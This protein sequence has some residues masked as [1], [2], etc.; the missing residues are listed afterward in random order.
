MSSVARRELP[1]VSCVVYLTDRNIEKTNDEFTAMWMVKAL[2]GDEI[3][4]AFT[5]PM[6]GGNTRTFTKA[7]VSEF[8]KMIPARMAKAILAN[9][10][11][12]ATLVPIPNSTVTSPDASD[13]KTL[14]LARDIAANSEGRLKAVPA[15]VFSEP[16]VSSR[17][18]GSRSA[19][20]LETVYRVVADV[21]GPIVLVDD[22]K[23]KSVHLLAAC[24]K[25]ESPKREVVLACTFGNTV[26]EHLDRPLSNRVEM[27]SIERAN[28]FSF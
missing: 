8:V 27:L 20:H 24:W 3:T 22:V 12:S 23:A 10:D 2:K 15:L 13:F 21:E 17:R 26:H 16:Q 6:V 5:V 25:L 14:Q 9:L 4:H 7:N 19:T 18:G 1:V 11:G 28:E